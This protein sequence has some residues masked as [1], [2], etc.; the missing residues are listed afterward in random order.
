MALSLQ[1]LLLAM[2]QVMFEK[3]TRASVLLGLQFSRLKK[4][5]GTGVLPFNV[6]GTKCSAR[7]E[8]FSNIT[9]GLK[10]SLGLIVRC[11]ME[12]SLVDRRN[13]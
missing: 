13:N 12:K 5:F 11:K 7:P 3:L 8:H 9:G 1:A 4:H 6:L 10:V 2:F